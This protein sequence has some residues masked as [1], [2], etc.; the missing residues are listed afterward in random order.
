MISLSIKLYFIIWIKQYLFIK[1]NPSANICYGIQHKAYIYNSNYIIV[2]FII[3]I[4]NDQS[5]IYIL[6]LPCKQMLNK[7]NKM[8]TVV[9]DCTS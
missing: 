2:K 3:G 1:Q 8:L 6:T 5:F 7:L 9:T 4:W